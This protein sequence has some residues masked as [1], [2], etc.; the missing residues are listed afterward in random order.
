MLPD[1]IKTL[2]S[3]GLQGEKEVTVSAWVKSKR[4]SKN[5]AFLAL[6]DGSCQEPLQA[7]VES[8][9]P[10]FESL[11]DVQTG[12]SVEVKGT[13]KESMGKGQ[14]VEILVSNLKI[15]GTVTASYPLQKKG[16]TLEFLREIAHLRGRS[17]TFSA[18][19][20][21]RNVLSQGV[22][23]YFSERGFLWAQ[24]PILTASDCE[25]A[26]E[27]FRVTS[28]SDE[29][30]AEAAKNPKAWAED[31]FGK[32]SFLTVSGQ[33]QA[34][35]LAMSHG[36]VYTFGPTFRAEN[37]NTTRHLA[38]F[39][40]I[41]PEM[42]FCDLTQNR[43]VAEDFVRFLI[44]Y[45]LEHC[46]EEIAFFEKFY[47]RTSV[48]SLRAIA[49][50]DFAHVT[51]T[52]AIELLKKAK[53][54]FEFPVEWGSD[55][56]TEHERYLSEVVFKKPVTVT[57]YPKEIKSF[58]MRLNDD[59]KTV[60]AMDLLIPKI[61]EL[62]GG[63]QREERYDVLERRMDELG[64]HKDELWWYLDLRR[65]GSVVHSGFGVGFE[66]LVMFVSGMQNIR[67]VILCPRSAKSINF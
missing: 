34:E 61:G 40:M 29:K 25:G 58:Y 36:K 18:M 65:Q 43:L 44:R 63:S 9:N 52:E 38:E 32:S 11:A 48:A 21:L 45:A 3:R 42:A 46:E 56:Q 54:D 24:T 30:L 17:N 2:F 7:V 5:L 47:K 20:R 39:W 1:T 66:R 23:K 50:A 60:A 49:D 59:G 37:S 35:M 53:K 4:V 15:L 10:C 31:F 6:T 67:D 14:S 57:D 62:I 41:E 19:F 26:G 28:L 13:L 12:A 55:L 51:Y 33:L 27:L 8:S 64:I 22:H 16:H